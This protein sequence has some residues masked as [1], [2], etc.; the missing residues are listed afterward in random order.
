M[1]GDDMVEPQLLE[2]GQGLDPV[3]GVPVVQK[4]HPVD[5]RIAGHNDLFLRQVG[6]EIAVRVRAAEHVELDLTSPFV[7][8]RPRCDGSCRERWF[9]VLQFLEV[10]LSLP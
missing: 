9:D 2:R 5:Q 10:L 1:A 7:Q 8:G 4:R 3:F 6:E